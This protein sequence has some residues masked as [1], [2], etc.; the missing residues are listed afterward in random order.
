[1]ADNG[2]WTL[3]I[4]CRK[5][6]V[7]IAVRLPLAVAISWGGFWLLRKLIGWMEGEIHQEINTIGMGLIVALGVAAGAAAGQILSRKLSEGTGLLGK[8]LLFLTCVPFVAGLWALQQ[9]VGSTSPEW[10]NISFWLFSIAG[11][12]GCVMAW[13]Q[14]SLDS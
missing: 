9:I 2:D 11:F 8:Y 1:M 3:G 7:Q 10:T 12:A 4:G 13:W 5:A 6:A 14:F